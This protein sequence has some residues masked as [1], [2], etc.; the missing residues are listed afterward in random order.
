[1]PP[2]DDAAIA[3]RLAEAGDADA[4]WPIFEEVVRAGDTYAFD[5]EIEREEGMAAWMAPGVRCYV[6]EAGGVVAGTYVLKPNQQGPGSHVANASFMVASSARGQGIGLAMG[7]DSLEE[8]RRLG[9]RAMQFN[10]VVT[11][12]EAAIALWRKLGFE[13]A[14]RLPG[15]FRRGDEYVDALVMYRSLV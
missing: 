15:A 1:M 3:I 12:N 6:A 4:I 13:V 10:L 9:F 14:G 5:P 11:T 7:E 8:A 2:G